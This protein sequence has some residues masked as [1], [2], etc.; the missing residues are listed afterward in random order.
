MY[1]MYFL[2]SCVKRVFMCG[3]KNFQQQSFW[4]PDWKTWLFG[5]L[6]I[7]FKKNYTNFF[8]MSM[9]HHKISVGANLWWG[10][11]N[12]LWLSECLQIENWLRKKIF[13]TE[14]LCNK[15]TRWCKTK[16]KTQIV[17]LWLCQ[18]KCKCQTYL[19]ALWVYSTGK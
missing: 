9:S 4:Y 6:L 18:Y 5:Q 11:E 16:T 1:S 3:K 10:Q 13:F 8:A 17:F 12:S 2:L 14:Q 15:E 7:F 19:L